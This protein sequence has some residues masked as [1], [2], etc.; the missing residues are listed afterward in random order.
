MTCKEYR[1]RRDNLQNRIKALLQ[2]E[3]RVN[4]L[5]DDLGCDRCHEEDACA[6]CKYKKLCDTEYAASL[7]R[8]ALSAELAQLFNQR[9]EGL[10]K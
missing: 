6:T 10:A 8:G 3:I 1:E 9:K 7:K 2:A 5:L 4:D